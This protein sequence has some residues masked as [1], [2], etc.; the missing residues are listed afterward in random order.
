[1]TK[2]MSEKQL[3]AL[4]KGREK[5]RKMRGKKRSGKK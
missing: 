4:R 3:A 1:M 2:K 5:L